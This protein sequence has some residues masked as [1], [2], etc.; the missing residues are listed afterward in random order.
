MGKRFLCQIAVLL[1]AAPSLYGQAPSPSLAVDAADPAAAAPATPSPQSTAECQPLPRVWANAEYLLWWIK[2]GPVAAPLV[3]TSTDNPPSLHSGNLGQPGTQVLFGQQDLDYGAF[4]GLRVGA[5]AWIDPGGTFGVEARGL[6]LEQRSV[7]WS[8]QSDSTG[9]PLLAL[10][11]RATD[12]QETKYTVTIPAVGSIPPQV[13]GVAVSS[14]S[15]LDGAEANGVVNVIRRGA[16]STD[17]LAGVRYLS[18]EEDL[19]V[20]TNALAGFGPLGSLT[21]ATSDRFDTQNHFAGG[22][23]GS[24]FGYSVGRVS[25]DVLGQVALGTTHQVVNVNGNSAF[26]GTGTMVGLLPASTEAGVYAQPSNSGRLTH[27]EFTVVPEMQLRFGIDVMPGIRTSVGYNFLYWSSVVRPGDQI[28]RTINPAQSLLLGG[29][30][31]LSGPARPSGPFGQSDL[32]TQGLSL[33][34]ELGW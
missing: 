9:T 20:G 12:G 26:T 30:G 33:A 28:D 25:M 29:S 32:W 4:S 24:R 13:G 27:D 21:T 10:P 22:Q 17:L 1:V 5:G 16:I 31:V 11:F 2:S 3:T 15:N 8:A 7:R 23:L 19:Q 18:L 6:I 14:T 34:V